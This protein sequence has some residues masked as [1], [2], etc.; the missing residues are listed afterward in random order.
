[1]LFVTPMLTVNGIEI[2]LIW[3]VKF[4]FAPEDVGTGTAAL[5]G[6]TNTPWLKSLVK[7]LL[8][9]LVGNELFFI[10]WSMYL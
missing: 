10:M 2:L 9:S 5:V 6:L 7:S 3:H 4:I 1:M 8:K